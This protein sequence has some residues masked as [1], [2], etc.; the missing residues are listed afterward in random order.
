[1]VTFEESITFHLNG[2]SIEVVHAPPAHTDGDSFIHFHKA[3]VIH[4]GDL[5]FN[6]SYPFIDLGAG[7][8][9]DGAIA[10][11]DLLLARSND[12]TR[13]IPGH[14]KVGTRAELIAFQSMLKTAR[15]KVRAAMA[16]ADD[17][18]D[19]V[20]AQPLAE[21]DDPWGKGYLPSDVFVQIIYA[22]LSKA[23]R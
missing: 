18:G 13:F 10:A 23:P 21:L 16:N 20:A 2:D 5:F 1:V 22:C 8:S 17:V 6:G 12:E 3:N 11:C 9:V 4:C 7:G 14:G 15:D 19:V